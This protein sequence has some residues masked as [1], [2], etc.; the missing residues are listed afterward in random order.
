MASG[1]QAAS[2]GVKAIIRNSTDVEPRMWFCEPG[3][4][5]VSSCPRTASSIIYLSHMPALVGPHPAAQ[6]F[7]YLLASRTGH[8]E[9]DRDGKK[10]GLSASEAIEE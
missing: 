9:M 4:M 10:L 5:L 2:T 6:A 8:Q 1:E 3:K 7:P